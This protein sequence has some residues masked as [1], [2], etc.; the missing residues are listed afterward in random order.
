MTILLLAAALVLALPPLAHGL[1]LLLHPRRPRVPEAARGEPQRFLFLIPAHNEEEIIEPC[2]RSLLAMDYPAGRARVV[3]IADNCTDR[4][5][6]VSRAAGAEALE[7]HDL[8][9]RGK[10]R[11]IAWALGHQDLNALDAVVIIDADS[12]V[13]PTFARAIEATGPLRDSAGQAYFATLNENDN[14][15]TLLAGVLAR[16]RY[17]VTY[18]QRER[19]GL[20]C[21]LTGNGMVLGAG[22]LTERGWN[23]FSLTENWELYASLTADGVPIRYIRGA[24]LLSQEVQNL[25]QGVSQRRRWV[26]G[27]RETLRQW[28]KPLV[29]SRRIG[30]AQKADA[31]FEL[32]APGPVMGGAMAFVIALAGVGLVGGPKGWIIAGTALCSQTPMAFAVLTV[33]VHHPRPVRVFGAMAL[34]PIYAIWRVGVSLTSLMGS[35]RMGW[36]KTRRNISQP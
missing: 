36:Q 29:T 6:E 33:L 1:M 30:F 23:A 34:L 7:R 35:R 27:R 8:V 13:E 3:V 26:V 19:A 32:A 31:L 4:T 21:P 15:L 20:N 5:A 28:I 22:L 16:A 25:S 11:A 9:L 24:K 17:E 14:W 2:V 12:V 10:P 18:P